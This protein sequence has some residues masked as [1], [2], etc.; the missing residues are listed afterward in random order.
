MYQRCIDGDCRAE[1]NVLTKAK[2]WPRAKR[3]SLSP[4]QVHEVLRGHAA[5][6]LDKPVSAY[7]LARQVGSTYKP[8]QAILQ[9]CRERESTL[10]KR[11]NARL[12]MQGPLEFDCTS[13]RKIRVGPASKKYQGLVEE[14]RK[15]R[16]HVR[17]PR[18]FLLYFRVVGVCKRGSGQFAVR[19]LPLRL[20]PAAGKPPVESTA[21]VV[22]SGILK[23][24]QSGS[25]CFTDGAQAY[26]AA[27]RA[28]CPGKRLKW[29]EV[30]HS[31]S[32]FTATI[33]KTSGV[34]LSGTQT[35]DRLWHR[36][37]MAVPKE[38]N[39]RQ[40]GW[41]NVDG[42]MKFVHAWMWR[43]SQKKD[44]LFFALGKAMRD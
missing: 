16:K 12:C 25:T 32:Q 9:A 8:V 38:L 18:H 14:W 23:C 6:L 30:V 2:W 26:K 36:L 7:K 28:S 40:K 43:R 3:N 33:R 37:K 34:K 44:T 19:P 39:N 17:L 27:H 15:R 11:S 41:M 42:F 13:L 4:M 31:R 24:A 21:E 1:F 22:S 10:G 5:A 20:V 35:L 29:R